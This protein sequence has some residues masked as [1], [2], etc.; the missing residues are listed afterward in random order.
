MAV[1]D[2]YCNLTRFKQSFFSAYLWIGCATTGDHFHQVLLLRVFLRSS[3]PV[4]VD[5]SNSSA[6]TIRK[7]FPAYQKRPVRHGPQSPLSKDRFS[8]SSEHNT[9]IT[10]WLSV[11]QSFFFFFF[12]CCG[13][14]IVMTSYF[15]NF[16]NEF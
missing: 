9:I 8:Q 5:V 3:N 7:K 6:D 14:D 1:N 15:N 12:K 13:E 4:P 16:D 10:F 2:S 11:I